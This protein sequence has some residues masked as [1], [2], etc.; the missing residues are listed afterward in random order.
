MTLQSSEHAAELEKPL[1]VAR[2]AD[3]SSN[4]E[5]AKR[6]LC[7]DA[8]SYIVSELALICEAAHLAEFVRTEGINFLAKKARQRS[9]LV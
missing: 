2:I 8:R 9:N 3:A 5:R 4:E 6:R 1:L 7:D